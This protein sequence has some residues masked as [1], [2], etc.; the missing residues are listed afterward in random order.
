MKSINALIATTNYDDAF[1]LLRMQEGSYSTALKQL[2]IKIG[3]VETNIE[4]I[5]N[6]IL[7]KGNDNIFAFFDELKTIVA[8]GYKLNTVNT[9]M[10][11]AD[12]IEKY[13]MNY[14]H[15]IQTQIVNK[16]TQ[17]ELQKLNQSNLH[18]F[19]QAR[20]DHVRRQRTMRIGLSRSNRM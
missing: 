19:V 14:H 15:F 7:D 11:M 1:E 9:N 20:L 17:T 10:L 6:K 5:T 13:D 12:C 18:K 4:Y 2:M 3:S 8:S 16:M